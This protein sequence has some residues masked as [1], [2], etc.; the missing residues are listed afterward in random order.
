[1]NQATPLQDSNRLPWIDTARGFA[2]FGIFMV[3]LASFHAPYFMYGNGHN[4]WGT[5]EAGIWQVILD[6][7]F[8]ASFYSLFSFLFGF[9]AQIIYENLQKKQVASPR[10]WLIR[11]FVILLVI[12]LLHAFLIWYGDILIT[13]AV[14]GFLL[15]LFLRRSNRTILAWSISVLLIPV[16]LYSGLL[17]LVS[18]IENLENLSDQ[19]AIAAAFQHYGAGSWTD[20]LSQNATDWFYG[21][22]PMNF[23]FVLLNILPIFLL[24]LVFARNK[25]LHDIDQNQK[26][27]KRWW[28][29][30]FVIFMLCKAG[31][32]VLGNPIWLSLI[33]DE[34]GGTA[35]AIFYMITIAFSYRYAK[36]LFDLIGYV[37]KM[38]L[39]NYI[40][41]S[42]IGVMLF[43]SIGFGLYGEL[44]PW[45]TFFVGIIVYPLQVL[46]SYLWLKRYKRGP[47]EWLWRSLI[48]QKKLT[49][50]RSAEDS[51][52][53]EQT[54]N[55]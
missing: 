41:Q 45:Q 14:I 17:F 23:F 13:Y 43:Y 9:G 28:I 44:S 40:L 16:L 8:Q 27:L 33:Q 48:Y 19:A 38:A 6:I 37:G 31:P 47:I 22:S 54:V 5:G 32:Y 15:L 52:K 53:E 7:F 18:L 1:M 25:W 20:I 51:Q 46:F 50:K 10:K 30:S 24:G 34:F 55:S 35:S 12:G 29:G 2:I 3:N 21:N 11:R 36:Q 42:L 26:V 39:T 4:Y 49:N